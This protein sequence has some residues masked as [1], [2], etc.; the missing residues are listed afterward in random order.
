MRGF[1]PLISGAP[2]VSAARAK[3]IASTLTRRRTARR[4][5]TGAAAAAPA[6]ERSRGQRRRPLRRRA[7]AGRAPGPPQ[8]RARGG[9]RARGR[10]RS[11]SSD[12]ASAS[13]SHSST[14]RRSSA[15]DDPPRRPQGVPDGAVEELELSRHARPA[16]PPERTSTAQRWS[17]APSPGPC[18]RS[19]RGVAAQARAPSPA[20]AAPPRS[21]IAGSPPSSRSTAAR[22]AAAISLRCSSMR[23]PTATA[24]TPCL[25]AVFES[26]PGTGRTS[27]RD[28]NGLAIARLPAPA[29]TFTRAREARGKRLPNR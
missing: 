4:A 29:P 26:T 6:R 27:Q 5:P 28:S 8:A 25:P 24:R 18:V 23:R 1:A 2:R 22:H 20:G 14:A 19:A 17:P 12:V 10:A 9:P 21:P 7:G 11:R 16:A 13:S 15:A 3:N